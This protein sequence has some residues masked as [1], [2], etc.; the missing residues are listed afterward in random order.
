M[1]RIEKLLNTGSVAYNKAK[2]FSQNAMMFHQRLIA[3]FLRKRGWV[4]FYLEERDR[5]CKGHCWLDRYQSEIGN[6]K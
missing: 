6:Y 4:V 1:K 3:N 5:K 2:V